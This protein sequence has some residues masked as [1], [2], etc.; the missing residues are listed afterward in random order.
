MRI[1]RLHA[2]L[3]WFG[4]VLCATSKP[5][6]MRAQLHRALIKNDL[7]G[8]IH[9][10]TST[11]WRHDMAFID[12][13]GYAAEMGKMEILVT[14]LEDPRALLGKTA[15]QA[16]TRACATNQHSTV[17]ALLA[18]TATQV[19]NAEKDLATAAQAPWLET[20]VELV[21]VGVD[22]SVLRYNQFSTS[23]YLSLVQ[24]L[25]ALPAVD[26]LHIKNR[27]RIN[28]L[29]PKVPHEGLMQAISDVK[30]GNDLD[31]DGFLITIAP[32]EARRMAMGCLFESACYTGNFRV[33]QKILHLGTDLLKNSGRLLTL[34][35]KLNQPLIFS[36][37][38]EQYS[39][40]SLETL[41]ELIGTLVRSKNIDGLGRCLMH[42]SRL[43]GSIRKDILAAKVLKRAEGSAERFRLLGLPHISKVMIVFAAVFANPN[44]EYFLTEV[45]MHIMLFRV[46][47]EIGKHL[48]LADSELDNLSNAVGKLVV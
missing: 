33:F 48:P 4:L 6:I 20:V 28:L 29:G 3:L 47:L 21:K 24:F 25:L 10:L 2:I 1:V 15:N 42:L 13:L 34:T 12:S 9:L 43:F 22:I 37:L 5:A 27:I 35:L 36:H 19:K 30:S 38:L 46:C 31:V 23:A 44:H 16:L 17:R 14:L 41:D 32:I 8:I 45:L 39:T 11:E 18:F 26:A 7:P 40:V